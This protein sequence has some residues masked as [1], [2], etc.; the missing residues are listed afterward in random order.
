ME[1]LSAITGMRNITAKTTKN[2]LLG[3]NMKNYNHA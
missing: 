2:K 1:T 3:K